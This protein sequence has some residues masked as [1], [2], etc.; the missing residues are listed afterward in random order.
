MKVVW[1]TETRAA[2]EEVER[3][4]GEMNMYDVDFFAIAVEIGCSNLLAKQIEFVLEQ[5]QFRNEPDE[6]ERRAKT[7]RV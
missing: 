1:N 3:I 4:S 2:T 6:M 5:R 7:V